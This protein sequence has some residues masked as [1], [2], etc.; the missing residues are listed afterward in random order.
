MPR[1]SPAPP[2]ASARSQARKSSLTV[3]WATAG[4]RPRAPSRCLPRSAV[5]TVFF[6]IRLGSI[7]FRRLARRAGKRSVDAD[8]TSGNW[9][10]NG[11]NLGF[12]PPPWEWAV[13]QRSISWPWEGAPEPGCEAEE[14][15]GRRGREDWLDNA[16]AGQKL[17]I[18]SVDRARL[19][20]AS[21]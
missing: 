18:P 6:A 15:D 14:G 8:T 1:V 4:A 11:R 17:R 5:V 19:V 2:S 16:L 9:I 20:Y 12:R 7:R 3:S 10:H 21:A 13:L